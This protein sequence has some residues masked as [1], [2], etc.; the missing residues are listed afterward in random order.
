MKMIIYLR[1]LP[2]LTALLFLFQLPVAAHASQTASTS[3]MPP[4][5]QTPDP[6]SDGKGALRRGDYAAAKTFFAAYLKDNPNDADALAMAGDASLGLKMYEDAAQS[7]VAA[8]KLQPALWSAHKNLVIAYAAEGKW[9]EFDQE[10][11]LLQ[12]ARTK[13][14]PGLGSK[15]VDVIDVFYIGA[16]RYIVRSY[17]ELN[18][19][20]KT[21]YNF[22]HFGADGKLDSWI[23]CESD[24][25]DQIFFAKA[26]PKEAAAGARS[27]SLDSYSAPTPSADG[28]GS[29]Q[30]HGTIKFYP[31]GEPTYETVRSDVMKALQHQS[32]AISSTTSEIPN[33]PAPTSPNPK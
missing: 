27:F 3:Q 31:D 9:T 6:L 23:A 28:R 25:V 14:A 19:R 30:T 33:A 22:T 16:E 21:R 5:A 15:D 4:Q 11:S 7:Y 18:G 8:I 13:G 10:R 32:G 1:D 2:K 26:H 29:T 20:Y 12:D 17:A 24:D